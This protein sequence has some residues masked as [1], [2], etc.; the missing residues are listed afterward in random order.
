MSG[1]AA[2]GG[3]TPFEPRHV[4]RSH[5]IRLPVAAVRAFEFFTPQGERDWVPG[6]NPVFLHPA[7]GRLQRGGAFLTDPASEDT[8][9]LWLVTDVDRERLAVSYARVTPASRIGLVDV[10]VT[11]ASDDECAVEVSYT[12]T[13]VS[14]AGNQY[15]AAFSE[16]HYRGY[17]ESWRDLVLA[18][19]AGG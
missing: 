10:R 18:H 1:H 13:A 17:I 15:L 12:F 11:P 6:W 8:R 2:T 19:L 14:D 3:T 9:T 7:D 4:S 16:E 5:T